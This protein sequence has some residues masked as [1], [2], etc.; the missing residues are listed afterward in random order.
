MR[1]RSKAEQDAAYHRLAYRI[2]L[3]IQKKRRSISRQ[4]LDCG[5]VV[6]QPE[7]FKRRETTPRSGEQQ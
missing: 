3:L 4:V 2:E 6:I 1:Q 7:I 5:C